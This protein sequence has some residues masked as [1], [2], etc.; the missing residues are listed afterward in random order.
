MERR[1]ESCRACREDGARRRRAFSFP[2]KAGFGAMHDIGNS[3][4]S[5]FA[6]KH[7]RT[8]TLLGSHQHQ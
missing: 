1:R 2:Y 6:R 4:Y 7:N 5:S 8:S 3:R